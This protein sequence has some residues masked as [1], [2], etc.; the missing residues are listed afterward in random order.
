MTLPIVVRPEARIDLVSA[1][2]W[3]DER[4]PD[5][6]LPVE[7]FEE[8]DE[9]VALIAERPEIFPLFRGEV[10]R[11]IMKQF[12]YGIYYAIEPEQ[13]VVLYFI[14]M[15]KEEEPSPRSR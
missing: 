11:A 13:I 4:E 5:S 8:F 2:E 14:A 7:L 12:P 15:A 1:A 10:R 6:M 9:M 3:Y